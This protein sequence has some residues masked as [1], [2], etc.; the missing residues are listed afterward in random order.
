MY[1]SRTVYVTHELFTCLH[2]LGTW[3]CCKCDMNQGHQLYIRVTNSIYDA[4]TV[5]MS[6]FV[7][8]VVIL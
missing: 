1:E 4:R 6:A 2:L 7:G 5:Y 8:E 3:S